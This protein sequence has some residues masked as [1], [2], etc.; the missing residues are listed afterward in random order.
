MRRNKISHRRKKDSYYT[1]LKLILICFLFLSIIMNNIAIR[2][3]GPFLYEVNSSLVKEDESGTILCIQDN[4]LYILIEK[5]NPESGSEIIVQIIDVQQP[6]NPIVIGSYELEGTLLDFK[7]KGGIA[8]ML[9]ELWILSYNRFFIATQNI[10]D[11]ANPVRLGNSALEWIQTYRVN[12]SEQI[13]VYKNYTYVSSDNL[14]IFDCNNP[15]SPVKV[16]NYSSTGGKLHVKN[17]LLYLVSNGMKI[18]NLTDPVNPAFLGEI[19]STKQFS[20]DSEV[21]GD[22]VINAFEE[23]GIECYNCTDPTQPTICGNYEFPE[24]EEDDEGIVYD[25]DI[26]EDRL[27]AGGDKLYIFNITDSQNLTRTAKLNSGDQDISQI[28]VLNDYFYLTILSKVKI[29]FF[30]IMSPTSLIVGIGKS[31]GLSILVGAS[32]L[33]IFVKR[34]R[35]K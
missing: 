12:C 14:T 29:Y 17:D 30:G 13:C 9:I 6:A 34:K 24:G 32:I 15:T 5:F 11:P 1:Q 10:T 3:E 27:F 35:I 21:Y 8:Y 31:I 19:N 16:A 23:S 33:I 7:I 28:K 26:V 20:T 4:F 2:G 18:F 22:Y 25:I